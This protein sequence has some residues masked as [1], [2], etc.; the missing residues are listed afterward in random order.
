MTSIS[1]ISTRRHG[2]TCQTYEMRSDPRFRS[3]SPAQLEYGHLQHDSFSLNNGPY[4]WCVG[5]IPQNSQLNSDSSLARPSHSSWCLRSL[6][7]AIDNTQ[8]STINNRCFLIAVFLC[9]K[10]G[11]LLIQSCPMQSSPISK[12]NSKIFRIVYSNS[13]H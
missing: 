10:S 9:A 5:W 8:K 11:R 7:Y 13:I 12:K 6:P 4:R 1:V 2:Q 3:V